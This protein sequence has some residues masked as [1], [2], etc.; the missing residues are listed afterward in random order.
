MATLAFSALG[1]AVGG[2]ILP[3][4]GPIS[5]A[6]IGKAA[7]A[8]AG[9]YVDQ[10]LFGTSGQPTISEG[11]R[12]SDLNVTTSSEGQYIPRIYG[13]ARV[14]GQMIWATNFEEKIITR[15]QSTGQ[16]GGGKGGSS[17]GQTSTSIQY[18]YYANFAIALCEGEVT[19]LGRVWANGK[20]L[21]LANYTY[22]FYEGTETQQPD[23]LI[24]TKEGANNAPAYKGI[25]YIV[26]ERLPLSNFGNRIPQ[27]N[28]ELFRRL[29]EF[30]TN[31]NAITLIPTA[32]EYVYEN[33][34]LTKNLGDGASEPV[35]THTH[36]GK[37]DWDVAIDQLQDD[38][39][40]A[41]N[42][43]LFVS[44]FGTDLRV[45]ACEVKPAVDSKDKVIYGREWLVSDLTRQ[46]ADATSLDNGRPAYGGTPSDETVISAISDL[47]DRGLNVTFN[48]FLLMDI[49]AGNSLQDPYTGNPFQPKY[50]WRGRITL[51]PAPGLPGTPDKT[52]N[53]ISD[54]AAF[55]GQA[56]ISDFT[57]NQ[58]EVS[59]SGVNEWSYRRMV[60]HYAHLCEAAGGV[61]TFIIGSELRGLTTIR[62]AVG[63]FPFVS[64]LVQL[65]AD[66]KSI[67]G[68]NCKVTYAADWSEYFGYQP[69]DGTG[70]VFFHLDDLWAS[71]DIDAIGIDCYWP[72]S[73]WQSG[74]NHLDAQTYDS[75]YELDYLKSNVEGGE[76]YDWYYSSEENRKSQIRTSITDGQ[77]KPW[78]FRYKDIKSWWSNNHYNRPA[79]IEEAAPTNWVPQ[80]KPIWFMEVGCPAIHLG[81]NQPNV[82]VDP[83]SSESHIPYHS[84]GGRDDYIQRQYLKTI[85]EHFTPGLENFN[86]A[87][88]PQST[89][90]SGRMVDPDRIY[91]YTWD[92]RP[93]PAFPANLDIWG[94][95]ENW[96]KGHWLTG[97]TGSISL[98]ALVTQ[99]MT[100][101]K[102]NQFELPELEGVVDGY[103]IDRILP[104][105]DAL[106]P[107]ELAFF[108]DSFE[109]EG[110]IKFRHRANSQS[111]VTFTPDQLVEVK[112]E[113]PLFELTRGQETELPRS[114]KISFIDKK[115]D[116]RSR[117]FEGQQTIGSTN[118]V[119]TAEL[120]IV[121]DAD[122]VQS[123]SNKWVH[124]SWASR[125]EGAFALP[126][127][128]LAIEP[129]DTIKLQIGEELKQLRVTEI[130]EQSFRTIQAKSIDL[131]IYEDTIQSATLP[132][133]TLPS[134]FGPANAEFYDFPLLRGEEIAH[135][136]YLGAYQKPWPGSVAFY[137]SPEE[138]SYNLNTV[139]NAPSNIGSLLAVLNN[140][141]TGR[142]DYSNKLTV[143]M[144]NGELSSIDKLPVLAG[145]NLA[146][147]KH[148]QNIWEIIQFQSANLVGENTYE[149][150]GLLRGQGGT[151]DA[152]QSP[153]S[154]GSS[155]V[156]ID[157]ALVQANLSI[158]QI[159][160]ELNWRYG[161]AQYTIGHPSFQTEQVTFSK[162][163]LRPLSPVHIKG[164]Y[165]NGDLQISWI[166][167]SRIG[168]DSWELSEIPLG[169]E[170]E[171]YEVEIKNGL[172]TVRT[173]Q[174][175][176]TEMTY[177]TTDQ[178]ADWGVG[179]N[180]YLVRI[181]QI[182]EIYGR[183]SYGEAVVSNG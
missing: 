168:A 68:P 112:K 70:D 25:S 76:G 183:G 38:L 101:Y 36:Q 114:A 11:P 33:D 159:G 67:V 108:F 85:N 20:D 135:Q 121:M 82:F 146:A 63:G 179:Q 95:G 72:L 129:S 12:L 175:T 89:V 45:N 107:L 32:G 118:R 138:T 147:I 123:L 154:S 66:V 163:G 73:D 149:L 56:N 16:S 41:K 27:F 4:I 50:P 69:T 174:S 117:T 51:D 164:E 43:S 127:S 140:G 81:S 171:L 15:T 165:D 60:L 35:N 119:A 59:Y 21:N 99:I 94:D 40:N 177:S 78:V 13:A 74:K 28:F 1:S 14:A 172:E 52:A 88:N 180:S 116:Y 10:A 134:I 37:S 97:R 166:R 178:I 126:L 6:A 144:N 19:R 110:V 105:R 143:Q 170:S 71:A 92:A 113:N 23:S 125:E 173:L 104:A 136:G 151:E 54:I 87:N 141:P 91:V 130:N 48:P 55:V 132:T 139:L 84:D 47:K 162:R 152:M 29:D 18:N 7:G 167:R 142:W 157:E 83:K 103:V 34:E 24:E 131:N 100:D 155:F 22:R 2:S 31:I 181:Y 96:L 169:E 182:S 49:A 30:E 111:N 26:F 158:D 120:P 98:N 153:A 8:L 64:A 42:I 86:E 124:E 65:A 80:S 62:D 46:L 93:Y 145:G 109:S 58:N 115:S 156:L 90:Y 3:A 137:T 61:D 106:Q 122:I 39:P 17:Q 176:T 5:G 133:N 57:I 79:G 160:L 102:F 53:V 77:G 161:P 128:Q 9:R 75:I 148:D 44:W 150:T